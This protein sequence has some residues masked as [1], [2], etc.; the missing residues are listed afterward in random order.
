MSREKTPNLDEMLSAYLDGQLS[1]RPSNELKRMIRHD[2]EIAARFKALQRQRDLL[3]ALPVEKA[4]A[5]MA[6]DIL[7]NLERRFILDEYPKITGTSAGAR[8]LFTRRILAIA[9]MLLPLGVLA[10]VLWQILGPVSIPMPWAVNNKT[11]HPSPVD[12][13]NGG[14]EIP[15]ANPIYMAFSGSLELSTQA[16]A[17]MQNQ[18]PQAIFRNGLRD[19]S[20]PPHMEDNAMIYPI[21]GTAEQVAGLLEELRGIWVR[22][23]QATLT[24]HGPDATRAAVVEDVTVA[25]V[26]TIL[27]Q[28]S[29]QQ[30]MWAAE[31]YARANLLEKSMLLPGP[32]SRPNSPLEP[33]MPA[34]VGPSRYLRQ[35]GRADA[36]EPNVSLVITIRRL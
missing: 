9:A 36:D 1:D 26:I 13:A 25:Q 32:Q 18:L 11:T 2:P 4:P 24:V 23:E 33:V 16:A 34:L 15:P 6:Q 3:G 7:A 28:P 8:Q 35:Q 14:N 12:P 10:V 27:N 30:R 5:T 19:T 21:R 20:A 17:D 22:C 29:D 31:R